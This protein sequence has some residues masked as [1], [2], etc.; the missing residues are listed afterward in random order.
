VSPNWTANAV[1][2]AQEN[3]DDQPKDRVRNDAVRDPESSYSFVSPG[4][5]KAMVDPILAMEKAA[6]G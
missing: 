3:H 1:D 2:L 4:P 5:A 6:V